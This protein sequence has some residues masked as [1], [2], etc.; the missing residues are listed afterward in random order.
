MKPS[1]ENLRAFADSIGRRQIMSTL[2]L[3]SA[4]AITNAIR[5]RAFP[6]DWFDGVE[7][8]AMA[9]GIECPREFFSFKVKQ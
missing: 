7:R 1:P 4:S 5:N 3:S 6:A 9:M 2:R 8:L